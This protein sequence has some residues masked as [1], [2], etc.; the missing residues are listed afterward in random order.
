MFSFLSGLLACRGW[1]VGHGVVSWG[2][3]VV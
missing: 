2:R 1:F 3:H